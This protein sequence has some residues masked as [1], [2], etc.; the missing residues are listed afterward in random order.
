MANK[1]SLYL[2]LDCE[3]ATLPFVNEWKLTAM[4]KQK[5][6]IAKPLIYDIGWVITDRQGNIYKKCSYLVQETFFVPNVFNTAYY[7][8][9]RPMYMQKLS[10][11]EIIPKLWNDIANELLQDCQRSNYVCAYNAQF[12]FKK[13]IPF[14]E[15]YI[16]KLYSENYNS[17]EY[18]QRKSAKDIIY[19]YTEKNKNWDAEHF[20]FRKQD[21]PVIDI[22]NVTTDQLVNKFTYKLACGELPMISNSGLYFKTSAEST[23]RFLVKDYDFNEEH[24]ALA[25]A[26]I[27]TEIL[28]IAFKQ[29]AKIQKGIVS[30]PFRELGTTT[31][32]ALTAM[33]KK[34]SKITKQ[35]VENIISVME[36]Y[37]K[38]TQ[39]E[40][41]YSNFA[42]NLYQQMSTLI[43]EM[44]KKFGTEK[45][46]KYPFY[47]EMAAIQRKKNQVKNARDTETKSKYE[48]ELAEMEDNL[49]KRMFSE[50]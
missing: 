19:G 14:T 10:K 1:K 30:F 27:E 5:I 39:G 45:E 12:D 2:I 34:N 49:N 44:N 43:V 25:D 9:K 35:A 21:F 50:E 46:N 28:K 15:R 18:G 26:E 42:I 23:F 20:N 17:W 32:W 40:N 47:A 3:T 37:L 7:R 13:A 38:G 6:A 33:E 11:K 36:E 8:D 41:T 29:H 16:E 31:D 4:E 48:K 24:T 22:W